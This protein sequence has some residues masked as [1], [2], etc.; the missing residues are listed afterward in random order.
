MEKDEY[1]KFPC[2]IRL[3]LVPEGDY[4]TALVVTD[5]FDTLANE[6]KVAL[7]EAWMTGLT[8]FQNKLNSDGAIL[9]AKDY[10]IH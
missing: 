4:S 3:V 6:V 10:V 1:E 2:L 7:I 9:R 5:V 8:D